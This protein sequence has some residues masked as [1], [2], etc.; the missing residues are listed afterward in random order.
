MLQYDV[1]LDVAFKNRDLSLFLHL[2]TGLLAYCQ[3]PNVTG[4]LSCPSCIECS[5]GLL[6]AIMPNH[7]HSALDTPDCTVLCRLSDCLSFE[8]VRLSATVP[9]IS[10]QDAEED[11]W[12]MLSNKCVYF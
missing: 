2:I 9:A 5:M 6:S 11:N 8:S 1:P 3:Q 4:L 12:K 7:L 10:V